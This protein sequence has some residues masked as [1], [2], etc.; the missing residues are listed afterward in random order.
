[1]RKNRFD[2]ENRVAIV[3]GAGQGIGAAIA[4]VFVEHGATVVLADLNQENLAH[5]VERIKRK[6]ALAERVL[7]LQTDV[8]KA[9]DVSCLITKAC[10]RFKTVDIL[11]N[12]A[13]IA[14]GTGIEDISKQEWDRVLDVNINGVFLCTQAVLPVMKRNRYGR[15]V[16]MA[17]IAGR[18]VST[19]GGAH[20]T[21]SKAAVLGFTRAVAKE[22]G[23][24][25]ITVNAVCPGFIDTEMSR[26]N[27][28]PEQ[29]Q[30]YVS[31]YPIPR[32]GE[33]GEVADAVL[34]LAGQSASYITGAA[35]DVNGGDLMI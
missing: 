4:E 17:S 18:S 20:Y 5:Q 32:V 34:F 15:I 25:G 31:T 23:G 30:A 29:T 26:L 21:T 7:G 6:G 28:S 33:P 8:T 14:K 19:I 27:C 1:M 35:I 11:V 22:T 12:N 9:E 24:W 3:T 16:N 2:Q 10:E 13:G